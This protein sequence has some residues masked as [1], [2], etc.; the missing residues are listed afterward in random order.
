MMWK[1]TFKWEKTW[2]QENAFKKFSREGEE[3]GPWERFKLYKYRW[4]EAG[5]MGEVENIV[6]MT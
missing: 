5:N 3:I 4:E 1:I 6:E 2:E